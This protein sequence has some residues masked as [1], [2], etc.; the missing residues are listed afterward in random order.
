MAW[1]HGYEGRLIPI[2]RIHPKE[3][4][5]CEKVAHAAQEGI[6]VNVAGV[7]DY[8]TIGELGETEIREIAKAGGGIYQIVGTGQLARTVQMMT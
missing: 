1:S 4:N 8:G 6:T 7:L 3:K 2:L 5:I